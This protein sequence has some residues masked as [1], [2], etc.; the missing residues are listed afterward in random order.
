VLH[1]LIEQYKPGIVGID[2]LS[3]MDDYREKKG[4]QERLKYTHVAEDLYLTSEKYGIPILAPAQA[5]REAEKDSK[6]N[7]EKSPELHQIAESDGVGQNATRVIGI[8]QIGMTMKLTVRKNRYGPK[9]QEVLLIWDIENGIVK[10]FLHV[11]TNEKGK[12]T[13]VKKTSTVLSGE[14]LF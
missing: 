7:N 11:A 4:D 3:L 9:N 5:S 14:E 2:Q 13:E 6:A 1:G 10:P 12:A 8:K